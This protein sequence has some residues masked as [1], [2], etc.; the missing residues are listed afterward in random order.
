MQNRRLA[1]DHRILPGA[2]GAASLLRQ[3]HA[4]LG[5]CRTSLGGD[6]G[7][8]A[9]RYQRATTQVIGAA[10]RMKK[11]EELLIEYLQRVYELAKDEA[12]AGCGAR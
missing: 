6:A 3:E 1:M 10:R 9:A 11:R 2:I 7:G 12:A 5:D 4:G 8:T